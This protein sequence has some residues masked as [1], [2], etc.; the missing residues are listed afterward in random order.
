V[1]GRNASLSAGAGE[2]EKKFA[3]LQSA[4]EHSKGQTRYDDARRTA[5]E[6]RDAP[7]PWPASPSP[8]GGRRSIVRH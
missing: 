8:G 4:S 1:D 7:L 6:L 3:M 5:W 2:E